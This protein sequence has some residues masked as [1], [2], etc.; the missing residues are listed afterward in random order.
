MIVP[1]PQP[2]SS[3]R[4]PGRRCGEEIAGRVLRRPPAVAAQHRLVVPVGVHVVCHR[5]AIVAQL[6]PAHQPVDRRYGSVMARPVGERPYMPDYGVDTADWEPLP[7]TWAAERLAAARNYWIVTVSASGRPHALPVWA[8]WDDDELRLAFSCGPRS[9]K[10]A[11]LAANPQL[12]VASEDTVECLSVGGP[13]HARRRRTAGGLDRPLPRQVHPAVART[14]RRLPAPEPRL[15]GRPAA[16]AGD[17]RAGGRVR[18]AS[19]TVALRRQ[20]TPGRWA[21]RRR[22]GD[23]RHTGG[24]TEGCYL[25]VLTWFA[26]TRCTGP[27]RHLATHRTS[28][29]RRPS[30]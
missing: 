4:S 17:H 3:S 30:R 11:N 8:V 10:A 14:E 28:A 29:S 19:H 27:D 9:R 16:G 20:L 18:H 5:R 21:P 12:V 1:G 26:G 25:P 15:R 24:T 2:T 22:P 13:G 7:W 6:A 23:L